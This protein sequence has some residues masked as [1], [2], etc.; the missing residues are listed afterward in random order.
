M[1]IQELEDYV[2]KA[3][4]LNYLLTDRRNILASIKSHKDGVERCEAQLVD[5]D[6]RLKEVVSEKLGVKLK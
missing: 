1:T 6:N 4:S 3:S 5:I 2:K